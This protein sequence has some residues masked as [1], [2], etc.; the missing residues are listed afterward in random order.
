MSEPVERPHSFYWNDATGRDHINKFYSPE[1]SRFE[2]E[3][4]VTDDVIAQYPATWRAYR[5]GKSNK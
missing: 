3:F 4:V 1:A 5:L 2:A